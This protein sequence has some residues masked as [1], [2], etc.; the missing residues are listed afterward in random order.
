MYVMISLPRIGVSVSHDHTIEELMFVASKSF[1][2]F[3]N[4]QERRKVHLETLDAIVVPA[5]R[6][7]GLRNFSRELGCLLCLSSVHDKKITLD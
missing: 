7:R 3:F 4:E 1:A 2:D 6:P 5:N